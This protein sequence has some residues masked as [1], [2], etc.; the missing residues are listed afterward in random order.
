M[1]FRDDFI[2]KNIVKKYP[3]IDVNEHKS[4]TLNTND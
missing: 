4:K 3:N 1:I 2:A